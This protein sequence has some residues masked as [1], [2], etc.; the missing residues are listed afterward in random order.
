MAMGPPVE[1]T[2]PDGSR[3]GDEHSRVVRSAG[4]VGAAVFLSRITGL[5]REVIFANFFGASYVYDAFL[6]AFRIPNLFRDLLGEGAL[7][8]A[9]VSVFSQELTTKGERD[10][11][12]LYN[13]LT[14]VLVPVVGLVCL[15]LIL[16]MPEVVDLMAPGFAATPGKREL[17]IVMG[18]IMAPFLLFIALAAQAMG[19]LNAKG[20][21]GIPAAASASFNIV[22]VVAGLAI[23]YWLG[24][25]WGFEPIVGMAC[26]ALLGGMAQYAVQ[27]PSLR[28]A[29]LPFAF[30][31]D[32]QDPALRKVLRLML[33]AVVGAAAVQANVVI[34]LNFASQLVDAAGNVLDGPVSWLGYAF[35]F[36]QLPLGLFGVAVASATLPAI[37]RSAAAGRKD[38]F[39]DTLSRSLGLVFL[40]TGPA[41]VG[42]IVLREPIVGLIYERGE[43]TAYDTHQTAAALACYCAGLAAYAAVKVLT[44]AYYALEDVRIPMLVAAFS[45]ALNYG[46]NWTFVH[47]LG[48]GHSGLALST[49]LVAALNF[50]Q[51][52]WFMRAKT[53]GLQG[54]RLANSLVRIA[55]ATAGM[56]AACWAVSEGLI[57]TLGV[58]FWG[59]LATVSVSVAVGV[60]VLYALC[61]ALR[62]PELEAAKRAVLSRVIRTG[63]RA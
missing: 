29:G 16:F 43:F 4:V 26:G 9:F 48:W 8:A 62:V 23:G 18:R 27:I 53:N 19:A 28:A 38:E 33:P 35:R 49:S 3:P 1:L 5:V 54:R 61:I 51:L 41:A 10:A 56:G 47:V 22:S 60:G 37:S 39:R 21:F 50:V 15:L 45:I 32:L 24:P 7:S 17:T 58:G 13:L 2:S 14:T 30:A 12:R 34:N 25:V 6:A 52:F 31:F 57:S 36:M 55:A 11:L 40:L 42:L 46:L 20:K 44:P 63:R 59:R